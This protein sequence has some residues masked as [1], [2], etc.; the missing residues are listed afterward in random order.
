MTFGSQLSVDTNMVMGSLATG[1]AASGIA[2]MLTKTGA[3]GTDGTDAT[4]NWNGTQIGYPGTGTINTGQ[5]SGRAG[6]QGSGVMIDGGSRGI[7]TT[8]IEGTTKGYGGAGQRIVGY[9]PGF[10]YEADHGCIR[11]TRIS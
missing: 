9:T 11:I 10:A 4:S 5:T 8:S 7:P 2:A 3:S 1:G 6:N